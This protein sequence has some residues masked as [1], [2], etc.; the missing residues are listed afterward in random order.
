MYIYNMWFGIIAKFI[1]TVILW[2]WGLQPFKTRRPVYV[3]LTIAGLPVLFIFTEFFFYRQFALFP[4]HHTIQYHSPAFWLNSVF[5]LIITL[6]CVA[7]YFTRETFRNERQKR[8]LIESQLSTELKF[9]KTQVNPHFLFNTLNNLFSIAQR[10]KDSE[11]AAGISKLAGLMRYMLYDSAVASISLDKEIKNIT[12]YIALS[13][14]R[15]TNEEVVVSLTTKGI[16]SE[17]T[18]S[19]MIFL[20]FIENAFKHGVNI[21]KIN[22]ISITIEAL[23]EKIIFQ[24]LNPIV[25]P[26]AIEYKEYGGIGLENVKRRLL[27]LYPG[28]H[29]LIIKDTGNNFTV[30]LE[31]NLL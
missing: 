4:E 15:Y 31:L 6:I 22:N 11:T 1:Y 20:P 13:K 26:S 27:L 30:Y 9:L 25:E 17:A 24:C 7:I 19:P 12:D 29:K 21:E 14:L 18:I 8:E 2:R 5:Y 3:F 28:K 10:N 23:Q 16:L